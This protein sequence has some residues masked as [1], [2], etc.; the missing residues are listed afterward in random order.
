MN[1]AA[2]HPRSKFWSVGYIKRDVKGGNLGSANLVL[3]PFNSGGNNIVFYKE[4]SKVP[5]KGSPIDLVQF[6]PL[7]EAGVDVGDPL[8]ANWNELFDGQNHLPV[9]QMVAPGISI[10]E[11]LPQSPQG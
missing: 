10:S 7:K 5:L 1:F 8:D 9:A 4:S 6:M 3:L 11:P 2:T